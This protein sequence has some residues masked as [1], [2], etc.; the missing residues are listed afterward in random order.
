LNP[1][2]IALSSPRNFTK[3][4]TMKKDMTTVPK[5]MSL[6]DF[7]QRKTKIIGEHM[8]TTNQKTV[9]R[10]ATPAK[11]NRGARSTSLRVESSTAEN[12]F[13]TM[14]L[15]RS[16]SRPFPEELLTVIEAK[17]DVGF[18]NQ[19]FIRGEGPGLSWSKGEKLTCVEG[20]T[21]RWMTSGDEPLIFKL[22][23]NDEIWSSGENLEAVPGAKVEL[24]PTF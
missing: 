13:A 10:K 3:N 16:K 6:R 12:A 18:G 1:A 7:F 17:M 22:L 9:S 19:L 8:K 4:H 14:P 24:V 20:N 2:I 15:E 5:M 23:L 11:T 21:W